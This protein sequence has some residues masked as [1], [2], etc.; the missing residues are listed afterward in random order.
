MFCWCALT[1]RKGMMLSLAM[2]WS[3][4]GAPV[5]DWSPAPHVEKKEPITM[6]HGDGHDSVPTTRFPFTESPNLTFTE[7]ENSRLS[8]EKTQ[9]KEEW[10]RQKT[11]T[12][13]AAQLPPH[14]LQTT[15][16]SWDLTTL[17]FRKHHQTKHLHRRRD[18]FQKLRVCKDTDERRGEDGQNGPDGNRALSVFQISRPVWAGHDSWRTN[19]HSWLSTWTSVN[20]IQ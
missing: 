17:T 16:H 6:T 8:H 13:P 19:T 20:L 2:A 18:T 11:L 10:N 4:R 7:K 12:C 14:T 15:A 3:S 9:E 1:R 5:S